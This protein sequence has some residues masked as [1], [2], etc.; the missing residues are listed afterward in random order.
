MD[1]LQVPLS[2]AFG[3]QQADLILIFGLTTQSESSVT[4]SSPEGG[5]PR[6]GCG[7]VY[8]SRLS[9][10]LIYQTHK[11]SLRKLTLT[12]KLQFEKNRVFGPAQIGLKKLRSGRQ[13]FFVLFQT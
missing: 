9:A 4:P 10:S 12:D 2:P 6:V 5:K 8:H 7:I 11:N 1:E 13:V 3:G